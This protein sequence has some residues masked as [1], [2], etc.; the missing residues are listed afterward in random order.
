MDSAPAAEQRPG[1]TRPPGVPLTASWLGDRERWEQAAAGPDGVKEG[2]TTQWRPDG[3]LY[4][5]G[6]Y[7][8][9]ELDGAFT[10]FHP[11]GQIAREGIY[12]DGQPDGTMTAYG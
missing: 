11:N 9:G 8:A 6:R 5:R 2:D 10:M 12:V 3:T 1:D 7:R 4:L